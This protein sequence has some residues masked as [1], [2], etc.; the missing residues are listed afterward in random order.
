MRAGVASHAR[1]LTL[2]QSPGAGPRC[3]AP[4]ALAGIADTLVAAMDFRGLFDTQ[5]HLFSLGYRASEGSLDPGCYDLLASEGVSH[6]LR[7]DRQGDAPVSHW[8]GWAAVTR[9]AND[10][11][12]VSWSARCSNT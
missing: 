3:G 1:D 10:S 11:V 8:S 7:R 4:G 6:Q 2:M 5:R 9:S 12:L